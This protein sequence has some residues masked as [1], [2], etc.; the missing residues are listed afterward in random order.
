V[1]TVKA[2]FKQLL[3]ELLKST[4][5]GE[6]LLASELNSRLNAWR[7][8]AC[9][10]EI[11]FRSREMRRELIVSQK[12]QDGVM[13]MGE[14]REATR[15]LYWLLAENSDSFTTSSS[16]IAGIAHC[17]SRTGFDILSVDGIIDQPLETPC[18]VHFDP[19]S[20]INS[21][22]QPNYALEGLGR[23]RQPRTTVPIAN[24]EEAMS[25]FPIK[26]EIANWCRQAWKSGRDCARFV[27]M[28][29]CTP[30]KQ[31]LFQKDVTYRILDLGSPSERVRSEI[32]HLAHLLGFKA[33]QELC[34][35]L[36]QVFAREP[37][38]T[39]SFLIQQ[40]GNALPKTFVIGLDGSVTMQSP[41]FIG[42]S[43]FNDQRKVDAF[44]A[45]Q[46]FFM[47][48]YY[49][50][51]LSNSFVDTSSLKVQTVD[52]AWSFRSVTLLKRMSQFAIRASTDGLRREQVLEIL[53]SLFFSYNVNV[54][55]AG[56]G[57]Y[58]LGIMERRA[59]FANSLL[60]P[61]LL[62]EDIGKFK[63]IDVDASGVPR[64]MNGVVRPGHAFGFQPCFDNLTPARRIRESRPPEDF[65]KHIEAD[66]DGDA[67]RMSIC[68]RYKGRRLATVNPCMADQ[69]FLF[70][71]VRPVPN[72]REG[73][74]D[75][76]LECTVDHLLAGKAITSSNYPVIVQAYGRP[77]M[78]W[79]YCGMCNEPDL[80]RMASNCLLTALEAIPGRSDADGRPSNIRIVIAGD[81]IKRSV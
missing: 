73:V 66:W 32:Q 80:I 39:L 79:A 67:Q 10:R 37:Q 64:D 33:N 11:H 58:C 63:L 20:V 8:A 31:D 21:Q 24:P 15:L 28:E 81:G 51:F 36:E 14:A 27:H 53:A 46:A 9:V 76:A 78:R 12:I 43:G 4:E 54:G 75:E 18:R 19:S 29:V 61:C 71:Y 49:D 25:A 3:L 6:E 16:D 2:I 69:S 41:G 40:L 22:V 47:G 70:A 72:P 56:P 5:N 60:S 45:L 59:V 26:P 68:I 57:Q 74:I 23:F 7:S 44:T 52:G 50:V 38:D 13:P 65:T 30:T 62:P 77:C 1:G 34:M 17:L 42:D 35:A 55:F 48:Y